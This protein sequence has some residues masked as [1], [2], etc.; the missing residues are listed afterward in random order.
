[1]DLID[2]ILHFLFWSGAHIIKAR[3]RLDDNTCCT[4]FYLFDLKEMILGADR[5]WPIVQ[6]FLK[7]TKRDDDN[8]QIVQ[9]SL[10]CCL[11]DYRVSHRTTDLVYGFRCVCR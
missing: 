4:A 7:I 5:L 8:R 9:G 6:E 1:M 10:Y 3:S 2:G 11:L